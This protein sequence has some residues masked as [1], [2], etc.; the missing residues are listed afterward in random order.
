[1][2]EPPQVAK[3]ALQAPKATQVRNKGA[4]VAVQPEAALQTREP[5]AWLPAAQVA[6]PVVWPR[7]AAALVV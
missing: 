5:A 7:V 2:P 3:S 1:M 6:A 4:V